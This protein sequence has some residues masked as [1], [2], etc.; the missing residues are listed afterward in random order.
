[1]TWQFAVLWGHWNGQRGASDLLIPH[2]TC[3]HLLSP[4]SFTLHPISLRCLGV[5]GVKPWK[6]VGLTLSCVGYI[7]WDLV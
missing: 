3:G 2:I 1:M 6:D 7:S 4:R 5:T